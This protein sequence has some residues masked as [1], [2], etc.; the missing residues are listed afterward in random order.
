MYLS[1]GGWEAGVG[2]AKQAGQGPW[3]AA[4][5]TGGGNGWTRCL[6]TL[7]REDDSSISQ[8]LIKQSGV[9]ISGPQPTQRP[10]CSDKV[11]QA[12]H[13]SGDRELDSCSPASMETTQ[14]PAA[15]GMRGASYPRDAA[16]GGTKMEESRIEISGSVWRVACQEVEVPRLRVKGWRWWFDNGG[17]QDTSLASEDHHGCRQPANTREASYHNEKAISHGELQMSH[18][19]FHTSSLRRGRQRRCH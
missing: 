11:G 19:T 2:P 15:A 8:A 12:I 17:G 3:M 6:G 14:W 10:S 13:Q 9:T 7:L 5:Q 4:W 1:L 18:N 16:V